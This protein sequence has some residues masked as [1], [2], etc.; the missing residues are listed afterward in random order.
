M[1]LTHVHGT[2][3]GRDGENSAPPMSRLLHVR[4]TNHHVYTLEHLHPIGLL[5][6]LKVPSIVWVDVAMDFIEGFPRVCGKLVVL[7][8]IERFSKYAHFIALGH[9]YTT[10]TVTHTFFDNIV[11]LHGIPSSIMSDWDPMFTGQFWR[12]LFS[13][14]VLN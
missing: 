4:S 5:Q 3:H 10:T 13:W 8:I 9:P 11:Q 7:T 2:G 1:V 12:E 14:Q 6:S